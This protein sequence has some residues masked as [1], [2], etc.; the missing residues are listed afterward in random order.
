MLEKEMMQY[1]GFRNTYDENGNPNGFEVRI[2][3][4]YYRAPY[5][6]QLRVGRVIV[7]DEVF[8]TETGDVT[9][10][11]Q[12]KE[13]TAAEMAEDCEDVWPVQEAAII[14]VKKPGGLSQGYHEVGVRWGYSCSYMPPSMEVFDDS[15]EP[16]GM[17][18]DYLPK[19]K[20]LIV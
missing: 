19:R 1:R 11:I 15:K 4:N 10:V 9:W 7:D 12:G 2:R 16:C 20:M 17:Y 5:L 3:T 18:G 6:S 14:R 8:L 13:Y